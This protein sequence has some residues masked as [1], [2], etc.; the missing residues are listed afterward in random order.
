MLAPV[1]AQET[2]AKKQPDKNQ[3]LVLVLSG[4]EKTVA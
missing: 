3:E 4:C 2:I 1:E